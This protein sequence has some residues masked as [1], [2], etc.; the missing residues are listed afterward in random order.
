MVWSA[1]ATGSVDAVAVLPLCDATADAGTDVW[2]QAGD[3]V[4]AANIANKRYR[5]KTSSMNHVRQFN[6]EANPNHLNK[7]TDLQLVRLNPVASAAV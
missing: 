1:S 4:P 7:I 5:I 6:T 3:N 2:A